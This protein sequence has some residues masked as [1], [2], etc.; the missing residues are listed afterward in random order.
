MHSTGNSA[1]QPDMYSLSQPGPSQGFAGRS[2]PQEPYYNSHGT[3]DYNSNQYST[4]IPQS[5]S[6]AKLG[7]ELSRAL[8]SSQIADS[9][10]T[11]RFVNALGFESLNNIP[12]L[13][14]IY[15]QDTKAFL[16]IQSISF[17]DIFTKLK[18]ESSL[19]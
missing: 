18:V 4:E 13:E 17:E 5:N 8:L 12:Q 6:D 15:Y 9:Y 16:G 3:S 14:G 1:Q 2:R 10:R 11:E 7:A 19:S